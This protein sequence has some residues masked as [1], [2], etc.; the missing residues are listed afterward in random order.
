M[1]PNLLCDTAGMTREQWL[2]CRMHGPDG[3]IPYTLGGSDVAAV[4]GVSPWTTP[5]ELW[6]IKKGLIQANDSANAVV[7]EMG[8]LME[9]IVAQCYAK[10]TGNKIISDTG[11]Y[12]HAEYPYA[13]A[14]LD[15][16][17]EEKGRQGVLEC[18]STTYHKA[19]D[20]AE[21]RIPYFYE[22]QVRY[23]LAVMDLDFADIACMWGFNPETDM[24]VCRICRDSA[25]EA[26]IFEKLDA[27]IESLELDI[28]PDM[29]NVQPDLAMAAL[30]RIY[31]ASKADLPTLEF[32]AP[33]ADAIRRIALLQ[34]EIKALQE[35]QAQNE[36]E[37]TAL[38]VPLAE[39]M[40]SHQHGVFEEPG[41]RFE[42]EYAPHVTRR[43][44]SKALKADYPDVYAAVLKATESRKIKIK[45]V[46]A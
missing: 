8:H 28:P 29:S 4:F 44:D 2:D 32:G 24:A 11:L 46:P 1:M 7:K 35:Q 12:Q 9:P 20:W 14:N 43:P 10:A 16:R 41:L 5:L 25:V 19:G 3:N 40:K 33:Q 17:V 42:V 23:Y 21:G 22:L 39:I 27:F 45:E 13:L 15:Y 6:H 31:S 18:K 26:L 34:A 38:S 36:K 37:V 30:A